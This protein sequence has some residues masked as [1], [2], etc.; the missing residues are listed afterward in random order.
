LSAT[1]P[2]S[3]ALSAIKFCGQLLTISS[4]FLSGIF[5][6]NLL[7]FV[8]AI[9]SKARICSEIEHETPGKFKERLFPSFLKSNFAA[10]LKNLTALSGLANQ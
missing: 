7:V 2:N 4:I 1:N 10:C 5:F 3:I 9:S 8:P 6:I